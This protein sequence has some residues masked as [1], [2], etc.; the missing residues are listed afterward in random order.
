V[1]EIFEKSILND[2]VVEQLA[3]TDDTWVKLKEMRVK[4]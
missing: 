2:E 1:E 4:Q 3:A